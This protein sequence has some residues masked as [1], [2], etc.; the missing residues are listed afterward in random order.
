MD[1]QEKKATNKEKKIS[2]RS[3]AE[4][5]RGGR[6]LGNGPPAET[7]S[8]AESSLEPIPGATAQQGGK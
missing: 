5:W 2:H 3:T 1:G 8:A 4:S 7:L 6:Q